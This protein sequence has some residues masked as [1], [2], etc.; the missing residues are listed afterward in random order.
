VHQTC[1]DAVATIVEAGER[2]RTL[3]RDAG[4]GQLLAEEP[5]V[6]VLR[7]DQDV[8]VRGRAGA[9]RAQL[10]MRNVPAADPEI[11]GIEADGRVDDGIGDAELAIELERARVHDERA[12]RRCDGGGLVDDA[13]AHTRAGEAQR[14]HEAGRTR[15]GDQDVDV[16]H[17]S[18]GFAIFDDSTDRRSLAGACCSLNDRRR[19]SL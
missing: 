1:D 2:A 14:E 13:H 12:G 8:R 7:E 19:P 15:A 5:L 9:E 10:D 16:V 6:L 4:G 3:D 11:Q 17:S 18:C